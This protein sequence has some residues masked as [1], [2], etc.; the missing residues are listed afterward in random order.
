MVL[1]CCDKIEVRS[2]LLLVLFRFPRFLVI[3][4]GVTRCLNIYAKE[5]TGPLFVF[6]ICQALNFSF[7]LLYSTIVLLFS[8]SLV[9]P[10]LIRRNS[11]SLGGSISSHKRRFGFLKVIIL[12]FFLLFYFSFVSIL[13]V[14]VM[15]ILKFDIVVQYRYF[16]W[17]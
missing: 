10:S 11:R 6:L 5:K 12:N 17:H 15:E 2:R 13:G 14:D 9:F 1:E 7:Q 3:G 16:W 8:F 4:R